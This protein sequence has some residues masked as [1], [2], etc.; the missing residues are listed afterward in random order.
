[1]YEKEKLH[2]GRK[3]TKAQE[4]SSCYRKALEQEDDQCRRE[5]L[6]KNLD[7]W[8]T[9]KAQI[10]SSKQIL[11]TMFAE[12]IEK[13]EK[14]ANFYDIHG[15]YDYPQF[16]ASGTPFH[17]LIL[18]AKEKS[19][20]M[21]PSFSH[22][23]YITPQHHH[24]HPHFVTPTFQHQQL[25]HFVTST[26]QHHHHQQP[27]LLQQHPQSFQQGFRYPPS[28]QH[29]N[30][31]PPENNM[32]QNKDGTASTTSAATTPKIPFRAHYHYC[33]GRYPIGVI[34]PYYVKQI[35]D[36][37]NTWTPPPEVQEHVFKFPPNYD[38]LG[39]L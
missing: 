22:S 32:D 25:P 27:Q 30:V 14:G 28:V 24:Q 31:Y 10:R 5:I 37:K 23:N 6:A 26:Y 9:Y 2:L 18:P 7:Q 13:F 15:Q 12:K 21:P 8:E 20:G 19:A 39:G 11:D 3:F 34:P 35:Q 36:D 17:D 33:G 1:M 38:L 16:H 29:S 4:N